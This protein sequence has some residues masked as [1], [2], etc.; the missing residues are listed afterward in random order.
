MR[1]E[2]HRITNDVGRAAPEDV[3]ADLEIRS[4]SDLD[5]AQAIG[6]RR[7]GMPRLEG[8]HIQSVR[9]R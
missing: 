8:G 9:R 6:E 4:R 7:I 5:V 2:R 1:L 3:A